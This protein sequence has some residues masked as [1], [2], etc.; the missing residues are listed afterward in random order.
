[1]AA[2][3]WRI[4]DALAMPAA[5]HHTA[6]APEPAPGNDQGAPP[7]LVRG[8]EDPPL[9]FKEGWHAKRDGVV[10]AAPC[11]ASCFAANLFLNSPG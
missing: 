7:R 11:L 3:A 6:P 5:A 2:A 8:G 1:M 10:R 4:H 9:L